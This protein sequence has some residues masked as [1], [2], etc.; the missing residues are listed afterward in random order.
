[1]PSLSQGAPA[2]PSGAGAPGSRFKLAAAVVVTLAAWGS[3]FAG[4]R[5]ALVGY[6]PTHMALLRYLVASLTLVGYAAAVRMP[7]PR[8]RDLPGLAA[9]GLIGISFYH[10]ALNYGE[11]AVPAAT[12]SFIIASA[13]VWMAL[14]GALFLHERL[15][16]WGWA[17]ILVSFGGVGVIAWEQAGGPGGLAVGGPLLGPALAVFGASVASA[18]Y[19]LGQKPYLERYSAL[20]TAAYIVWT[21]TAFLLPFAPGLAAE[22]ARAP[23]SAT[24]ACV[25]IGV[26]PG[27]LGYVTWSYVLSKTPASRAGS[28]LYFV[29]VVALVVAWFWLGEVPGPGSLVGGLLVLAGVVMVNVRATLE[30]RGRL[31]SPAPVPSPPVRAG[32]AQEADRA[33]VRAADQAAD[34][35]AASPGQRVGQGQPD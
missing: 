29:P 20:Q 33:A 2:P 34:R 9:V 3:A 24:L 27:A 23:L 8:G 31:V 11:T 30:R 12:A 14:L 19:S 32:T 21:G 18:L 15:G 1:M 10:T 17:G 6:S 35:A 28:F 26:V 5:A 13:P 16:P 22:A 7:L 25:Y 4:I